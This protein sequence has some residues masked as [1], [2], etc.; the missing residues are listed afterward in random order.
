VTI[1][2]CGERLVISQA[3][4]LMKNPQNQGTIPRVVNCMFTPERKLAEA[5]N[6][7]KLNVCVMS[8]GDERDRTANL[9]VANQALS[10][11]SYVPF[12]RRGLRCQP[13]RVIHG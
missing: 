2:R 7:R 12:P 8:S 11:L 6:G 10:Q 5:N 4:A 13:G 9:L 1:W 3:L